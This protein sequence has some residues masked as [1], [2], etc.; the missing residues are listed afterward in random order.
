MRHLNILLDR[1]PRGSLTHDLR[2]FDKLSCTTLGINTMQAL[3][4]SDRIEANCLGGRLRSHDLAA[5]SSFMFAARSKGSVWDLRLAISEAKR[6]NRSKW[7]ALRRGGFV[8]CSSA[9]SLPWGL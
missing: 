8:P 2:A 6:P 4:E 1:L 5:R 3:A 9:W 7:R